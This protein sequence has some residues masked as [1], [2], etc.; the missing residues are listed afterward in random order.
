M[1][2]CSPR[3]EARET[4]KSLA[5]VTDEFR[6]PAVIDTSDALTEQ[7]TRT[8]RR[9][10]RELADEGV[11]QQRCKGSP[12][13]VS[14]IESVEQEPE[15]SEYWQEGPLRILHCYADWGIEA[16]ALSSLGEVVRIGWNARDTNQSHPIRADAHHL[17]FDPDGE[18][19]D[20][21]LF[22]PPC[23]RYA[24]VTSISGDPEDHAN[25]IPHAREIARHYCDDYIIENKPQAVKAEDG[26]HRPEGGALVTFD[27]KQFGKR[28][29]YARSF[30]C[31]FPV[32]RNPVQQPLETEV[33]PYWYSDRSTEFWRCL[34]GYSGNYP[35]K[36]IAKNAV[37]RSVIDELLMA[38]LRARGEKDSLPARSTHSDP[39]PS[40][41]V[42]DD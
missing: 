10:L 37:P 1:S 23:A 35:K 34:K 38:F 20:L 42:A 4:I 18:Q 16:E 39:A 28:L 24:D 36:R 13:W 7:Q 22:H 21:G 2:N 17:P 29:K 9:A 26:L 14:Q 19:F 8:V 41:A 3:I 6:L 5:R 11:V 31:S 15:Q 27:R 25:E 12:Y 32:E 30:E 40:E 33:S